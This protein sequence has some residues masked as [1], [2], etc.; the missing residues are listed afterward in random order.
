MRHETFSVAQ[1]EA[2]NRLAAAI[3]KLHHY[4]QNLLTVGY[5]DDR[6]D[7]SIALPSVIK[8]RAAAHSQD[9]CCK[10]GF[11]LLWETKSRQHTII[12]KAR[13][14]RASHAGFVC[15][16]NGISSCISFQFSSYK[17]TTLLEP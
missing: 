14:K 13:Q 5:F 6:L 3:S 7:F 10:K 4:A 17:L 16:K 2:I 1:V 11:L 15:K 12:T 9:T 8:P